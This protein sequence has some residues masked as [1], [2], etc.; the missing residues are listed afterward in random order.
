MTTDHDTFSSHV[1]VQP[2]PWPKE[3]VAGRSGHVQQGTQ[4][5]RHPM[6][7]AEEAQRGDRS[8]LGVWESRRLSS[9]EL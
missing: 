3:G 6:D 8:N 5:I 2:W 1:V 9:A 7:R 4:P